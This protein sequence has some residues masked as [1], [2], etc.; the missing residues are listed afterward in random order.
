M[1][2]NTGHISVLLNEAV[3]AL[4]LQRGLW[5]VDG[6]L[7]GGGHAEAILLASKGKLLGI[8]KDEAA[9]SRTKQRLAQF[10]D[11]VIY[12]HDDFTN[13]KNIVM[14]N[15]DV[16]IDGA[17]LD[18]GVSSYQ[19]DET[20][21]GFSYSKDAPIDMRMDK[22]A[23][24]S[25]DDVVNQYS[26]E[27]LRRIIYTYGEERFGGRI[28]AAIVKN[29]PIHSTL[30]LAEIIKAAIPAANRRTGPHPARRTFQAIR[31]E[32]NSEISNLQAAVEDFIACLA[33]GGR[34]SI[35]TFHSLEDRIVKN[36]FR[37]AQDPCTCPKD[38]PMCVCGKKQQGKVIT[39][40]P[41]LPSEEEI[42]QNPRARS[43]KLRVFEK[44]NS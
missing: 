9:I 19:L 3:A 25:A 17:V 15:G 10:S 12:V 34:I 40:K 2:N 21:R 26:E 5:F 43:A 1:T 18:L 22:S 28:A 30:Q 33:P 42:K 41:I 7:G 11:R 24:F 37:T 27:E 20:D 6:T 44:I 29:R 32:T 16:K 39:R 38:I 13:I 8:D 4:P 14:Q 36:V 23:R 35:I 31:I